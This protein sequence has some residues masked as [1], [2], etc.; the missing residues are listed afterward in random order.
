MFLP[1]CQWSEDLAST[2]PEGIPNYHNAWSPVVH[3]EKALGVSLVRFD[4]PESVH[5]HR[6]EGHERCEGRY[7]HIKHA[8][9]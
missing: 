2:L 6:L 4:V 3:N 1:I 9:A 8:L 5:L 7:P